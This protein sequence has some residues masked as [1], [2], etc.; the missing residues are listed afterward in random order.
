MTEHRIGTQEEWQA[1]RDEL[2]GEEK[3]LTRRGDELARRR[4]ELPWVRV[5]KDY[6]F[7]TE[8]GEKT[9]LE[10]P[11]RLPPRSRLP[12]HPRGASDIPRR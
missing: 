4:R 10:R 1:A 9:L 8:E 7:D 12:V 5:E 11:Q 3:E 2:L 6:R